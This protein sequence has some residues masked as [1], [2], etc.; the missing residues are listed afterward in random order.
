MG[1]WPEFERGDGT[2]NRYKKINDLL[3][4]LIKDLEIDLWTLDALWWFILE[5]DRLPQPSSNS[6]VQFVERGER[7]ALERQLEAFLLENWACTSL[8]TEWDIYGTQEDPEAGNQ[9][10]TDVGRIDILARHKTEPR[11][12]VV[13]L[14]RDQSTDQTVGQAVRYMGWV[15]KHLAKNGEGVE[16]LIIAHK[17]DKSAQYAILSVPNISLMTYEIEFSLNEAPALPE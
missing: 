17:V 1:I 2:G 7:F 8:A 9:Y 5:S 6:S 12:L 10:P 15:K 13:E 3:I 4:R 11:F 16:A 14:K